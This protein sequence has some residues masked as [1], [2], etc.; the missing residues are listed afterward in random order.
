MSIGH[1]GKEYILLTTPTLVS[2]ELLEENTE[3]EKKSCED[4][5]S[6]AEVQNLVI[7]FF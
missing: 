2:E 7:V 1:Q 3:I 4:F 6:K 5:S